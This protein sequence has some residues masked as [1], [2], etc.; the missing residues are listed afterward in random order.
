MT[1]PKFPNQKKK[2]AQNQM[3]LVH[4]SIRPSKKTSYQILSK[5]FHNIETKGTL[6]NSFYEATIMLIPKPHKV[7]TKKENFRPIPLMN[8]D[9][10]ILNE[11]LA[12]RTQDHIK[13][14]IHHEQ[15]GFMTG[16]QGWFNIQ[17]SIIVT[18]YINK[19]N[20]KKTT[21]PFH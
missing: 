19:L 18:Y 8:M 2:N 12:N 6:P 17:K 10:K 3:G 7:P 14:I 11:I 5:L 15:V 21:C 4:N 9:A 16:M 1:A 20:E 13:T